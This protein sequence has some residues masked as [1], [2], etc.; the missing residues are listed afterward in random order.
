MTTQPPRVQKLYTLFTTMAPILPVQLQVNS[1]MTQKQSLQSIAEQIVSLTRTKIQELKAE[2]PDRRLILV[3]MHASSSLA[4]QVALVEQVSGVVCFGFSYNTVHGP[5]GNPDDHVLNLSTPILFMIG[6]N[7]ARTSEEEVES[8]REKLT[9]PSTLLTVG[10]AD[11]FLRISKK[12][13]KLEGVTQEMV[14]NMIVDEIAEFAT[15]CIQR[16]LPQKPKAISTFGNVT[17]HR[18][19]DSSTAAQIRKRKSSQNIEG[20]GSIKMSKIK[21]S[22]IMK[23]SSTTHFAS[24]DAVEMAVQSILPDSKGIF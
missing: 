20:D 1:I 5:R 19:I 2:N 21:A 4:L 23:P 16:P 3:G 22:K 6:Q 10:S 12:K 8:F 11:D 14:D 13:R 7:A 24:N 9:T 18:Q 17:I 15:K